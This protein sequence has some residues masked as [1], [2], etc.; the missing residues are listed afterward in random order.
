MKALFCLLL[1]KGIYTCPVVYWFTVAWCKS[2][3]GIKAATDFKIYV[4]K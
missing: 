4:Y 3:I 2:L 1:G